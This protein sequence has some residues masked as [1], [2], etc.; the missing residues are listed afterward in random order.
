[1]RRK[2]IFFF[3]SELIGC[4]ADGCRR[5]FRSCQRIESEM[6]SV[7]VRQTAA[8]AKKLIVR[9]SRAIFKEKGGCLQSPCFVNFSLFSLGNL[10]L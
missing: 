7:G 6:K 9:F 8:T 10:C 5:N 1:M 2:T 4:E 3:L